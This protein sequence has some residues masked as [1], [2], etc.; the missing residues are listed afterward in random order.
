[1]S[2]PLQFRTEWGS[3]WTKYEKI[4]DVELGA[5]WKWLFER[6]P[7]L[8]LSM[9]E[10]SS[11]PLKLSQPTTASI[12]LRHIPVSLERIVRSPAYPDERQLAAILGQQVVPVAAYPGKEGFEHGSLTCSNILLNTNG[13]VKT[14]CCH[15]ISQPS[16]EPHD[17]RA[18][19]F[20]TME[21]M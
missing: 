19:S 13:G 6:P 8:S 21:L 4:Y 16:G 20:I 9:T 10:L 18:L 14:K 1:M 3:P 17:V 7:P 11:P 2:G 15:V 12:V 5:P